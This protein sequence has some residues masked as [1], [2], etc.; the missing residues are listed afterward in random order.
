MKRQIVLLALTAAIV[1]FFSCKKTEGATSPKTI[2][3]ID[4]INYEETKSV[5]TES[6]VKK[7][8]YALR[9]NTGLYAIDGEDKGD[10]STKTKWIAGLSLGESVMTGKTRRMTYNNREYDFI[11]VR[12]DDKNEGFSLAAQIA[13]GGVLAV[14]IEEKANLF[15]SPK[16][17]DVTNT[18]V[19]RK[20]VLVYLPETETGGFVEVKGVDGESNNAIPEGR[21]MRLNALSRNDS[22]IQSSILMQTAQTL[23]NANQ[24]IA[25]EALLKSAIQDYPDSVF[26]NEIYNIA[27]PST[28]ENHGED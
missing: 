12:R 16:T 28:D 10:S 25:R 19:S 18:I 5:T 11:E 24:T 7:Q 27:N 2:N 23:T 15:K 22:N 9:V 13:V 1:L 20:T 14:V 6:G 21:Y 8:G 26:F 3:T 17:V 4:T